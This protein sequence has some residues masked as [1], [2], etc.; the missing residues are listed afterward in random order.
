MWLLLI[1]LC[2]FSGCVTSVFSVFVTVGKDYTQEATVGIISRK[3]F[4]IWYTESASG[5]GM[6]AGYHPYRWDANCLAWTVFF[7]VV[8]V[9]ICY[10]IHF[11]KTK[12]RLI[13]LLGVILGIGCASITYL[14]LHDYYAPRI[15]SFTRIRSQIMEIE[16]SVQIYARERN[17]EFPET[18]DELT[19]PNDGKSSFLKKKTLID[20]W[21]KPIDF[22]RKA[23]RF[24]IRS[25]GPDRIM[26]TEDD[27]TSYVA[28]DE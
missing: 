10:G 18:L 12:R 21:G 8:V 2:S 6:G 17:G 28:S 22:E 7:M 27:I 25:S 11:V 4:P 19:L 14:L 1:T 26:G 9:F 13:I 16:K 15:A 23:D 5:M 20:P 3:G 24:I